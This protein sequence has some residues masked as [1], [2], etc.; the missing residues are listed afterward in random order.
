MPETE[1]VQEEQNAA[2]AAS[3]FNATDNPFAP[4]PGQ[5]GESAPEEPMADGKPPAE[6]SPKPEPRGTKDVQS[7][8]GFMTEEPGG[9]SEAPEWYGA[10]LES[11]PG[12][13]TKDGKIVGRF[14]S[15]PDLVKS[16]REMEKKFSRGETGQGPAKPEEYYSEDNFDA[17]KFAEEYGVDRELIN[18]QDEGWQGI[19]SAAQELGL[20]IQDQHRLMGSFY[21]YMVDKGL[22]RTEAQ[23]A[24]AFTE[25]LKE[26]LGENYAD[27]AEQ[28]ANFAYKVLAPNLTEFSRDSLDLLSADPRGIALMNELRHIYE[29]RKSSVVK[30]SAAAD[31]RESKDGLPDDLEELSKMMDSREVQFDE[32]LR[33]KVNRKYE[34]LASGRRKR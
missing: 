23:K 16:Y 34:K 32:E 14:D 27:V 31:P 11:L 7:L 15:I 20:S 5:G 21:K 13:M 3:G 12:D 30:P 8:K 33:E 10:M 2:G 4:D 19:A 26:H 29:G 18:T 17:G 25:G 22:V 1:P 24:E 9:E 6:P 28:T